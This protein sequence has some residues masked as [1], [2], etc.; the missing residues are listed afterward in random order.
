MP[1]ATA[2]RRDRSRGRI[3]VLP[4]GSLR[5]VVFVGRDPLT[6]RRLYLRELIPPEPTAETDAEKT[7]RRMVVELDE[8]RS[9][10]TAATVAQ[11]LARHFDL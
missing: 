5:V 8:Q 10:R 6:K 9:P 7:L 11:L 2:T 4:S 3:E 1:R